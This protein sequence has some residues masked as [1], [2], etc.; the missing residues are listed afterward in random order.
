A[1]DRLKRQLNFDRTQWSVPIVPTDQ[2]RAE[3]TQVRLDEG[4]QVAIA[5]RPE[6]LK[7][8]YVV[9]SDRI[10]Y[11]YWRIQTL[12]QLNLVGSYGAAG[13]AGTFLGPD[14]TDPTGQRRIVIDQ[15]GFND[16]FS[17]IFHVR[18]KNWSLGINLSYPLFNRAARG[19]RGSA[20]YTWE[21]D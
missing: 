20:R 3:T 21:S 17:D 19:Q 15:T 18:H 16:A 5:R 12:P 8:A 10:R 9:D 7:E 2:V 4:M 11:E 13:L 14:P 1:Q 6:I